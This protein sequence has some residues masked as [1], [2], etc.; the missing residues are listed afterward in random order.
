MSAYTA[1]TIPSFIPTKKLEYSITFLIHSLNTEIQHSSYLLLFVQEMFQFPS[2]KAS[3]P[4]NN[5]SFN[6]KGKLHWQNP[7]MNHYKDIRML[8]EAKM[9]KSPSFVMHFCETT[10]TTLAIFSKFCLTEIFLNGKR[11]GQLTA[12]AKPSQCITEF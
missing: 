5:C 2:I 9:Q 3:F 7:K 10:K 12:N 11:A 1:S 4:P 6:T 8:R